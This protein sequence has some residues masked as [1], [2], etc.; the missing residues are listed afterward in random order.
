M[1]AKT[2]FTAD[3]WKLVLESPMVASIAITAAAPSGLFGIL[4]ESFASG[5]A[6]LEAKSDPGA[7]ELI[8]AV[9]ADYETSEGRTIAKDGLQATLS[10]S[11]AGEIKDKAVAALHQVAALLD[12][13]AP[14]DAGAFKTW[15]RHVSQTVAESATEGG[16][17]GFGG[18]KVSEAEKATLGEISQ[19]LGLPA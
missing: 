18:V 13:K 7:N 11:K 9:V 2:D 15:L 17:L 5:R 4:K 12:G 16:F 14:A 1:T 6:L 10:G 8:K 19:A 3:E